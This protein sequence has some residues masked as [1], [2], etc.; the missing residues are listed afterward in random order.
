MAEFRAF[1]G[2]A[3]KIYYFI[4]RLNP[5]HIGHIKALEKM[6]ETANADGSTPLILL[7]SG[8]GGE[9]TMDNPVPF[10]TKEQFLRHILP[11]LSFTV[12]NMKNP[13]HDVPQWYS[14]VLTHVS[15]PESVQFIRFAG[16]KGENATKFSSLEKGL[17]KLGANITAGTV[18]IPPVV[19]N[20]AEEMSATIVRQHA[21]RCY[22]SDKGGGFREFEARFGHFYGEFTGQIY[23]DI[24]YP[25]LELSDEE[26]VSYVETKKLPKTGTKKGKSKK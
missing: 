5:P 3:L 7:G 21:Y 23:K 18:A 10:E 8:P 11:H 17:E 25:V 13:F 2:S 22:L 19:S 1:N 26:I 16:D 15:P 24:L 20:S 6:I 4:G 12:R 9:R 14:D